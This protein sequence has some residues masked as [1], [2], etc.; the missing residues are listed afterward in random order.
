MTELRHHLRLPWIAIAAV[1]WVLSLVSDASASGM[2]R[3]PGNDIRACCLNRVCT[4]CCCKPISAP[5]RR[6]SPLRPATLTAS[7]SGL[8][9][10]PSLP[11]GCRANAPG[12]PVRNPQLSSEDDTSGQDRGDS[13]DL[14]TERSPASTFAQLILH[15]SRPSKSPLYLRHARLLI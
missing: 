8:A 4:V 12:A 6:E 3:V 15:V 14:T 7:R 1:V 10:G 2:N 9:N 11:C 5:A 13:L